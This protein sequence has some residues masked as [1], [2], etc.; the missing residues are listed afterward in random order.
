VVKIKRKEVHPKFVPWLVQTSP[1][2]HQTV[3]KTSSKTS[4]KRQMSFSPFNDQ[5]QSTD[6][7]RP[8]LMYECAREHNER[9]MEEHASRVPRTGPFE[10]PPVPPK[11]RPPHQFGPTPRNHLKLEDVLSIGMMRGQ[12][13]RDDERE[14]SN[15]PSKTSRANQAAFSPLL[16]TFDVQLKPP[17]QWIGISK[18]IE[19]REMG[20]QFAN[21]PPVDIDPRWTFPQL[22]GFANASYTQMQPIQFKGTIDFILETVSKM[23][24]N[25]LRILDL[26][27]YEMAMQIALNIVFKKNVAYRDILRTELSNATS[28]NVGNM[29]NVGSVGNVSPLRG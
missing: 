29:G 2:R 9:V 1:R 28:G 18:R 11:L 4:S 13:C 8:Y 14:D 23:R 7:I 5:M 21:I 25:E 15:R 27:L 10:R 3:I 24:V 19:D 16:T 17:I 6:A 26:G 12:H 22:S 20:A